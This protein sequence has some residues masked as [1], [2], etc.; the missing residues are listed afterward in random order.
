M[1]RDVMGQL[2][3]ARA[4]EDCSGCSRR[5]A[6][7]RHTGNAG[8]HHQDH[9][10]SRLVA[11]HNPTRSIMPRHYLPCVTVLRKIE[12]QEGINNIDE[13]VKATDGVMVARHCLGNGQ[14]LRLVGRFV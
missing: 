10:D 13:I 1:R 8:S 6:H 5:E 9:L 12:N 11:F 7:S 2:T 14:G 3:R 4:D